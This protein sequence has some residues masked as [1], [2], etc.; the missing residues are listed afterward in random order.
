MPFF[1][2]IYTFAGSEKVLGNFSWDS[3]KVL[4]KSGIFCQ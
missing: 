1:L 4:E 2:Y 3:W